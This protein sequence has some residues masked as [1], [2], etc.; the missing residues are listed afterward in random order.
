MNVARISSETRHA[1]D[2]HD[3]GPRREI[4]NE[5]R[6]DIEVLMGPKL[7]TESKLSVKSG[8]E[9]RMGPRPISTKDEAVL[10]PRGKAAGGE[11]LSY[12]TRTIA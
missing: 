8:S 4:Y 11:L 2:R 1:H 10:R 9:L 5:I 7:R 6:A 3:A 12:R